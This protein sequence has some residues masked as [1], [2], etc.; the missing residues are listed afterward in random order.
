MSK[1]TIRVLMIEDTVLQVRTAKH[2]L[3]SSD[4]IH[5]EVEWA[6]NLADGLRLL[7]SQEFDVV[8]CDMQ[9]HDSYGV[10]TLHRL[11][12][13]S[14]NIPVVLL[15]NLEDEVLEYESLSSGAQDYL[16]Q[17]PD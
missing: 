9:L 12:N 11:Q 4:R 10:G 8:L 1:K 7:A 13:Q 2:M 14:Q 6:S 15:T 17:E 5:F 3:S 16:D